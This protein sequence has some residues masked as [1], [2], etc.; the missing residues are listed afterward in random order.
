[1]GS[2]IFGISEIRNSGKQGFKDRKIPGQNSF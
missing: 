2:Y 1:M